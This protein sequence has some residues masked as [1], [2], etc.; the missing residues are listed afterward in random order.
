MLLDPTG[1]LR[2]GRVGG[3][4]PTI[5]DLEPFAQLRVGDRQRR[6]GEEVVPADEGEQALLAKELPEG[7]HLGRRAIE[8]RH[9]LARLLISHELDDAEESNGTHS[10]DTW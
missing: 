10:A 8:W 5:D 2:N 3:R 1:R 4:Q 9:R 7:A 6:V